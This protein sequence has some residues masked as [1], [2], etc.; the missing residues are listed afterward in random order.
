MVVMV[1]AALWVLPMV[2]VAMSVVEQV[3]VEAG[4]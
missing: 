3:D 4:A 1:S 2:K